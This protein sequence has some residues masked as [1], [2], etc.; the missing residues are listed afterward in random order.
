MLPVRL[1]NTA[2][3]YNLVLHL[4]FVSGSLT[5]IE[6]WQPP[7]VWCCLSRQTCS[8]GFIG[9]VHCLPLCSASYV[10]V[11]TEVRIR[12]SCTLI[13]TAAHNTTHRFTD[14]RVSYQDNVTNPSSLTDT[15]PACTLHLNTWFL[16]SRYCWSPE[17]DYMSLLWEK[18]RGLKHLTVL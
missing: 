15:G 16:L 18:F 5:E 12:T 11:R 7:A 3:C 9:A 10:Q 14:E 2:D 17:L 1:I 6:V 13:R 4:R 8:E